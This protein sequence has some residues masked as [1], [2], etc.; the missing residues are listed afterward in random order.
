M[1]V[2]CNGPQMVCSRA[3]S[4]T[5]KLDEYILSEAEIMVSDTNTGDYELQKY[6]STLNYKNVTIVFMR[7]LSEFEEW[8][9]RNM[10]RWLCR[11]FIRRDYEY[12]IDLTLLSTMAEECDEAFFAW[13]KS[14]WDV[15]M[16]I[17]CFLVNDKTCYVY[18]T[19]KGKINMINTLDELLQYLVNESGIELEESDLISGNMIDVDILLR[20]IEFPTDLKNTIL[21]KSNTQIC[22][23]DLKKI[24]CKSNISIM[25]KI[26]MIE[27]LLKKENIYATLI[28]T[29]NAWKANSKDKKEVY[30]LLMEAKEHSFLD[31][32]NN[33][34]IAESWIE[35]AEEYN[36]YLVLYL[37]ERF[38][39]KD[40]KISDSPVCIYTIVDEAM[41]YLESSAN[42][43]VGGRIEVWEKNRNKPYE[44]IYEHRLTLYTDQR[45]I[46]G[47]EFMRISNLINDCDPFEPVTYQSKNKHYV[48]SRDDV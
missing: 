9:R 1:K 13:N 26:E 23:N 39:D 22:K 16:G 31:A 4:I 21:S 32:N 47:F 14:D 35:A 3:N 27:K 8:P 37:F 29:V 46:I 43:S 33:L 7:D 25:K 28:G 20:Y 15:F 44:I 40:G 48:N 38:I 18:G 45:N 24:I 2:F 5:K 17:L 30:R 42:D 34:S 41:R 36:D 11:E 19:N 10:G 12:D 6:L